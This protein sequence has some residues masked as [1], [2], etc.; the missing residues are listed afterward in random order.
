[1]WPALLAPLLEA[2]A[3]TLELTVIPAIVTL[4]LGLPL[5]VLLATI[6][7]KGFYEIPWLHRSVRGLLWVL[8]S[9][10]FLVIAIALLTWISFPERSVAIPA[11]LALIATSAFIVCVADSINSLDPGLTR[12][13]RAI[14][15]RKDQI[16]RNVLLPEAFPDI[17]LAWIVLI[18]RLLGWSAITGVI[19][20]GGLGELALRWSDP[21][22]SD[23]SLGL[24]MVAL[25]FLGL[26]ALTQGGSCLV[27]H[28][29]F[30]KTNRL[31]INE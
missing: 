21:A 2:T 31:A 15:A 24:A 18:R 4:V 12:N 23:K 8:R 6:H 7:L 17:L 30:G 14:G 19:G 5:G 3:Q 20:G 9:V 28:Y 13:G 16:I 1:M 29:S 22:F 25:I 10:P 11:I 27:S 26:A